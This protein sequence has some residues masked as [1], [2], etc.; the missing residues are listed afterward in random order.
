MLRLFGAPHLGHILGAY[1]ERFPLAPGAEQRIA[2]HQL[3][4]LLVHVV[5]FGGGY[6]E[7][8]IA[9]AEEALSAL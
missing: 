4:P 7:Q 8:A 5:L 1:R 2:L 3:Y 6:R 9:A